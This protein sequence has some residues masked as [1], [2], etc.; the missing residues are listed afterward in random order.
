MSLPNALRRYKLEPHEQVFAEIR[1]AAGLVIAREGVT[2]PQPAE[3]ILRLGLGVLNVLGEGLLKTMPADFSIEQKK[4]FGAATNLVMGTWAEMT[5][6]KPYDDPIHG[7]RNSDLETELKT[8]SRQSTLQATVD[9]AIADT[10]FDLLIETSPGQTIQ[11]VAA[12]YP[13][14]LAV[15]QEIDLHMI[16]VDDTPD[17]HDGTQRAILNAAVAIRA[18]ANQQE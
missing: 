13:V 2:N 7:S 5:Q 10:Q 14:L 9:R 1:N 3:R 17:K 16:E 8:L 12:E 11:K 4:S 6:L 15:G 18:L